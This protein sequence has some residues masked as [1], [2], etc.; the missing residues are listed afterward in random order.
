MTA[1]PNAE[2]AW[3]VLDHIDVD[4][5]SWNQGTWY[6]QTD[7]GTSACFAGWAVA[8]AG[9]RIDVDSEPDPDGAQYYAAIDGDRNITICG[10]AML[11]LG[12]VGIQVPCRC[13]DCGTTVGAA[14]LLFDAVN[15]REALGALVAE[16]FGPRP[17]HCSYTLP[18]PAHD[19]LKLANDE[20][21]DG[22]GASCPGT[23]GGAS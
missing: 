16:I 10:A 6:R 4:P 3:R 20:R 15:D 13:G 18:H 23:P 11:D 7:C 17:E 21:P 5:E 22:Q 14:D 1:K 2:L 8:L 12:L 9:H 19:W